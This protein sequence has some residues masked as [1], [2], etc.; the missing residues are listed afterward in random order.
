[1]FAENAEGSV[2]VEAFLDKGKKALLGSGHFNNKGGSSW[3]F[4]RAGLNY[5]SQPARRGYV[6]DFH[7]AVRH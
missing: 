6:N 7:F 5:F 4:A 3:T 1:M 2:Q